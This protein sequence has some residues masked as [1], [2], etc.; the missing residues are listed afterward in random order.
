[1]Q[2]LSKFTYNYSVYVASDNK[3]DWSS[4]PRYV[5]LLEM[6]NKSWSIGL[7]QNS[8]HLSPPPKWDEDEM[9]MY[10]ENLA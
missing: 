3:S 4:I 5:Q 6:C 10:N 1:M 2:F 7:T 9:Y 8:L